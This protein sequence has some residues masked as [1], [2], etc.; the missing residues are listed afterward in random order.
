MSEQDGPPQVPAGA[1]PPE[2]PFEEWPYARLRDAAFDRARDR[3]DV[4]F[5]VEL[6]AHTPALAATADEGGSLG[7]ISGSL[8]ESVEAARQAF[9]DEPG[10]LEPLF[11][12]VFATYL[13]EHPE[14]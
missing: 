12:A 6:M 5:F 7:E 2:P 13:R 8:I 1:A 14:H 10:E 4:R 11:R 3:H 9:R